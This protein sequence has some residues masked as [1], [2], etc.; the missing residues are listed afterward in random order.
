MSISP[1]ISVRNFV[2]VKNRPPH[3]NQQ[4]Y[5][6]ESRKFLPWYRKSPDLTYTTSTETKKIWKFFTVTIFYVSFSRAASWRTT[7][8]TSRSVVGISTQ[9]TCDQATIGQELTPEELEKSQAAV[10]ELRKR[11]GGWLS[12][13]GVWK[14]SRSP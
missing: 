10:L 2:T 1:H 3:N 8:L 5:L 11:P 9:P 14:T 13:E 7:D 4:H 6:L 12:W